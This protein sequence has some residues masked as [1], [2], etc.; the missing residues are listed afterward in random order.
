MRGNKFA[1]TFDGLAKL[2]K[3]PTTHTIAM[4]FLLDCVYRVV[5]DVY[6]VALPADAGEIVGTINVGADSVIKMTNPISVLI[7][8][9]VRAGL[10]VTQVLD[11]DTGEMRWRITC[12]DA[13]TTLD[14]TSEDMHTVDSHNIKPA[15]VPRTRGLS[16]ADG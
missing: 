11:T 1:Y 13:I 14:L 4:Q 8:Q 3:D 15:A 10:F 7:Q 12:G 6:G 5:Q 16:L 2:Q 9:P